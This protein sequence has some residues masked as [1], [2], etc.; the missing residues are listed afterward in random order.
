MGPIAFPDL[1]KLFV[2]GCVG[3]II[4]VPLGL[5]KAVELVW[6]AVSHLHWGTP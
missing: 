6:W 4:I 1:S 5:W 2:P 3:A